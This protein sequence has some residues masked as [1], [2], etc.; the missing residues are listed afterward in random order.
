MAVS[1]LP[2]PPPQVPLMDNG[3]KP[4][5]QGFE[6]LDRLQS[7][8]KQLKAVTNIF[9]GL[10]ATQA[11]ALLDIFTTA[12]NGVVPPSDG[13]TTKFLRADAIWQVPPI[14][15]MVFVG[16]VAAASGAT[17]SITSIPA[18]KALLVAY[19]NISH[20]DAGNQML[21]FALSTNNGSSYG[22]PQNMLA[23]VVANTVVGHGILTLMRMDQTSAFIYQ[24]SFSN[25][26]GTS[27]VETG[28]SGTV[29]AIQFSWSAG[30][31]DD[32]AGAFYAYTIP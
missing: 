28:T 11:T 13:G 16:S 26:N 5:Q 14:I 4:T 29:N 21:R 30:S 1:T 31:F 25:L 9:D 10:T 2:L 12:V 15:G 8:V 23:G 6:F 7:L 32:A 19:R 22:T 27:G 3:G 17:A 20:N 24:S 18:C